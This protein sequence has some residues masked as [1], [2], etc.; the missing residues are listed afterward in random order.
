MVVLYDEGEQATR[1]YA[2]D[3]LSSVHDTTVAKGPDC[4]GP[5][6]SPG[7]NVQLV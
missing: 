5:S 3:N 1:S 6:K 7:Q 2:A 4:S